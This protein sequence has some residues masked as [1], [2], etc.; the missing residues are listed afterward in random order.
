MS[1]KLMG[2]VFELDVSHG[3][4]SVLLAMADHGNDDGTGIFPGV[5]RLAWKTGYSE[6][7]VQN[8]LRSLEAKGLIVPVAYA[9]GGR[10][11]STEY[12]M[13]LEN[14]VK[15]PPFDPDKRVQSATVQKG[16]KSKRVQSARE[17]VKNSVQKGEIAIAPQPS[18]NTI[19]PSKESDTNVSGADAPPPAPSSKSKAP[20]SEPT[21]TPK[22]KN[23]SAPAADA[24]LADC[25]PAPAIDPRRRWFGLVVRA[26]LGVEDATDKSAALFVKAQRGRINTLAEMLD[27]SGATFEEFEAAYIG[28]DCQWFSLPVWQALDNAGRPTKRPT[29]DGLQ[30][31]LGQSLTNFAQR[32]PRPPA[33]ASPDGPPP[34]PPPREYAPEP[35]TPAAHVDHRQLWRQATQGGTGYGRDRS[36]DEK[37]S[38]RLAR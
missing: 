3:E 23:K 7:Q 16:A 29:L 9:Q 21:R 26:V 31:T 14:G 28:K 19:E 33:R 25:A 36:D 15:K 35:V 2:Q 8:I 22:T 6:R 5:L 4:Q 18:R 24:A 13:C 20:T 30:A 1:G 37:P 11:K 17:R 34:P 27:K 32:A 38:A 10:G 12:K